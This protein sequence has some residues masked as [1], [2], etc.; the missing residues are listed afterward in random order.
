MRLL[1]QA[2]ERE[3]AGTGNKLDN[4]RA[5]QQFFSEEA[6]VTLSKRDRA[7]LLAA[8]LLMTQIAGAPAAAAPAHDDEV[9]DVFLNRLLDEINVRR[10]VAGTQHLAYVPSSAN[11]AL[12]GFLAE[13]VP[14]LAWP[15][16]C[17]HHLVGGA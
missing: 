16:P 1:D 11:A 5:E 7:T 2:K 6:A 17:M 3:Q 15:G 12:A 14:L 8:L 10:D 4:A 9:S 13:T